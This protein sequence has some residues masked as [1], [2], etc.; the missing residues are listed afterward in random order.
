MNIA[1]ICSKQ[2]GSCLVSTWLLL[3]K[4]VGPV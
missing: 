2:A 3:E 4:H 1:P